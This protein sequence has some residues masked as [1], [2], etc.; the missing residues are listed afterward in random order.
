M[1]KIADRVLFQAGC[2]SA[3]TL[4]AL[5]AQAAGA[6]AQLNCPSSVPIAS[7]RIENVPPGWVPQVERPLYLHSAAPIDGPPQRKG[8]LTEY[9]VS[10]QKDMTRYSYRLPGSF[11]EGKW[12]QCAYGEYGQV[13]LSRQLDDAIRACHFTYKKGQKAGQQDI[14]IECE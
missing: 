1:S 10:T 7:L 14:H 2:L 3:L 5:V 12:L 8:V 11:P 6:T 13:T 9:K 4:Y